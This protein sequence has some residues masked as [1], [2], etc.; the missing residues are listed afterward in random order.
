MH[1]NL[2]IGMVE[3]PFVC[4]DYQVMTLGR[5]ELTVTAVKGQC[6]SPLDQGAKKTAS[7]D[8]VLSGIAFLSDLPAY[9]P[10]SAFACA[11]VAVV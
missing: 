11:R 3:A 5:F 7:Y 6:H 9:T 1:S 2:Q 10:L 4:F 8:E